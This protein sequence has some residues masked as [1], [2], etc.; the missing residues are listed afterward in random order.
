MKE[1]LP[2]QVY[3]NEYRAQAVL[4]VTRDGLSIAEAA[5]RLSMSLKTLANWVKRAKAGRLPATSNGASSGQRVVTEEQAEVSRLRRE[6]A[7]LRMERDILKKSAAYFGQRVAARYAVIQELRLDYPLA[8]LCRVLDVSRSGYHAWLVRQPS[9][10]TQSRERL[11]VAASAA[12]RRTRQTYGAQRLQKELASVGFGASLGTVKR[13]R[14]ELGLQCIQQKRCFRVTTT[15][16]QHQLPVAPNLLAQR[17]TVTRPD[18][19]WTADITY[20]PTDEGWLYVA[21]IK[22][23]FAGEIVGC[24]FGERMTTDLVVRAL[25]QAITTRRPAAGLVHHSDRGSQY[26]SHE[27]QAKLRSYGMRASMSRK[28][29]CYDNAPVESFWGTL[30]TELVHHRRYQTRAEAMYEISEYIGIFYNRQRRQARLGYLSPAAY[31][32]QFTRQQQAA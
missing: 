10:R 17:F 15:D 29:N 13:I 30:K 25:E 6:N 8:V 23:L 11:K 1:Q 12:H 24:A 21:A 5:R 16:S 7:E 4:L 9:K 20:V 3:T 14:R 2:K 27:Y 32:Q 18:E 19:A 31:T 22:D 26:G 28:G